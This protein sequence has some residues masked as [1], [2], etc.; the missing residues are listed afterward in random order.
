MKLSL[1][2]H[3]KRMVAYP[4]V[5]V[6][7]TSLLLEQ[8]A[9]AG[10]REQAK[11]IHDR[12]VG[13]PPTPA[14]L[15]A[16]SAKVAAG[17]GVDAALDAMRNPA[18]YNSTLK[19]FVTPWTNVERTVF[20]DL[21]DYTATV[22]GAVRDDVP[23]TDVL[24]E[25]ILYVGGSGTTTAA[26][27]VG[28][29]DHYAEL[30]AKRV[31]LSDPTKLVRS[32]QS[33]Q[34][35]S[36]VDASSAA[37]IITTR[38]FGAAFFSAGTNR[39]ALRFIALNYLCHDMEQLS[40]ITLPADR[41]RQDVSRSPGGDSALFLTN[42][43]GCHSGM[44][45]LTGAFA[46][47]DFDEKGGQL[48]YTAGKVQAKYLINSNTFPSGFVTTDDS[49]INY[50]RGGANAALGWSGAGNSGKGAKS[51]GMEIAHSKAFAQCQVQ[52]VFQQVCFRAPSSAQ[53]HTEVARI[54]TVFE[55]SNYNLKR[56]FAEV[57]NNCKG[58]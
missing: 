25:D 23:F 56:V 40:D 17:A 37:G 12:L 16:M 29:N 54:T 5:L 19:N 30:E 24:S 52:K 36:P 22:I 45:A 51:V 34:T 20:S 48:I 14:V 44:D 18:F 31:D 46:Y 41:V 35:N 2:Q 7:G 38:A 32:T 15:D 8:N 49:W 39:R 55:T 28:N 43:V 58:P 27:S 26:Y 53:D 21:N 3:A 11:R 47:Y 57:A 9:L 10:P 33:T 1:Y 50:W 42:C 13:V 6:L 4:L